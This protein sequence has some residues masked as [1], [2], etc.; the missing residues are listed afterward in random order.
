MKKNTFLPL[1][2]LLSMLLSAWSPAPAA[3]SAAASGETLTITNPIPKAVVVTLRGSKDYT[4]TVPANQTV[5]KTIDQ[6]KYRYKYQGC[7]DKTYAGILADKNGKFVLD[8]KPC[9]M[10]RLSIF[11]PFFTDYTSTLKGWMDYQLDVRAGQWEDFQIVAGPYWLSYTC[12]T[13]HWEGKVR[14]QKNILWVM[15]DK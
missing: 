9:K 12:G 11:N 7:L 10:I 15:C 13:K 1:I 14:L 3:A 5:V 6:G 8:I 2:L 4:F